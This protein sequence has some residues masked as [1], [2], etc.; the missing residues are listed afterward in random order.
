[1]VLDESSHFGCSVVCFGVVIF[2]LRPSS[3]V[4]VIVDVGDVNS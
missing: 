2:L 3:E 1:M 4:V